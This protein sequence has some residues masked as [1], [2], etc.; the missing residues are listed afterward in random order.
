M[1]YEPAQQHNSNINKQ[2]FI[3][4]ETRQNHNQTYASG[5]IHT[6]LFLGDFKQRQNGTEF[7][8]DNLGCVSLVAVL[9]KKIMGH[10][11]WIII[12]LNSY[13]FRTE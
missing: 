13:C 4:P 1:F 8:E 11:P 6:I 9:L 3:L 10:I 5:L 12:I 2:I 7:N